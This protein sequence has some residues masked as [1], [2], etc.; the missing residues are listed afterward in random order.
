MISTSPWEKP[1]PTGCSTNCRRRIGQCDFRLQQGTMSHQDVR[2]LH[3][4]TRKDRSTRKVRHARG[5]SKTTDW[6]W[7]VQSQ[8]ST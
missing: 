7:A 8:A 5:S 3:I 1:V 2:L 6:R 4:G